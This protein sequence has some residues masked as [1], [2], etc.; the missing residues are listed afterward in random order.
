M[1]GK[2]YRELPPVTIGAFADNAGL[3]GAALLAINRQGGTP[4]EGAV[5]R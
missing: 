5:P 2:D 4:T 1:S 3:V